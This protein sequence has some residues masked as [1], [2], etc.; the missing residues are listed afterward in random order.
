MF[1]ESQRLGEKSKLGIEIGSGEKIPPCVW[2]LLNFPFESAIKSHSGLRKRQSASYFSSD[3]LREK[4]SFCPTG[5]SWPHFLHRRACVYD[6][7]K[8]FRAPLPVTGWGWN[9][10]ERCIVAH[11]QSRAGFLSLGR[12]GK[13][14]GPVC[15]LLIVV[16]LSRLLATP[17]A[18]ALW[19]EEVSHA[20]SRPWTPVALQP[21]QEWRYLQR[22]SVWIPL[23]S[24]CHWCR[25]YFLSLSVWSH[26]CQVAFS[27]YEWGWNEAKSV[28]CSN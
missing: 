15:W 14:P 10:E 4:A 28:W 3:G 17:S 6:R 16:F 11:T 12:T 27:L 21:R 20:T 7:S 23:T 18:G 13:L 26:F 5:V 9:G 25:M 22:R 19:C 8:V 2:D 24:F 1:Q